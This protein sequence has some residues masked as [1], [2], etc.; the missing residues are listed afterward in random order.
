VGGEQAR[1]ALRL[2][3]D[4]D[5]DVLAEAAVVALEEML[6]YTGDEAEAAPL[7]DDDNDDDMD[8]DFDDWESGPDAGD[9]PPARRRR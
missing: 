4:G 5:D 2:V 7:F 6:F 8:D 3:A 9:E 1:D